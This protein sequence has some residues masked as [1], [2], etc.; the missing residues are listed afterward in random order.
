MLL[1]AAKTLRE[2]EALR[3]A[4]ARARELAR[5]E[6]RAL[7]REV[8]DKVTKLA[9][10]G[11][12]LVAAL[13]WNDAIQAAFKQWFRRP[14]D[15][16]IAKFV[17]AVLITVFV[18]FV[19]IQLSRLTQLFKRKVAVSKPSRNQKSPPPRKP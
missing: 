1:R 13:A 14:Q 18:V 16:L 5:E 3:R 4:A 11:F 19:T 8:L 2:R 9:T 15:S 10:A 17:Y 7:V 12:G 6:R